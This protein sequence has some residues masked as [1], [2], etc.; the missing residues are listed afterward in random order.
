MV[1]MVEK[2]MN[3]L[4]N[5]KYQINI[6]ISIHNIKNKF[7]SYLVKKKQKSEVPEPT[8]TY[9]LVYTSQSSV[10]WAY[11]KSILCIQKG[12]LACWTNSFSQSVFRL[13][14]L[15]GFVQE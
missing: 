3:F 2:K 4:Q 9:T 5:S 12:E 15:P 13:L 11:K 8:H 14:K 10:H 1:L 6:F 7:T